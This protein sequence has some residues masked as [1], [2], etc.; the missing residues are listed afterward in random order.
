MAFPAEVRDYIN[1][2]P[3]LYGATK[4]IR[5]DRL[6]Q[7]IFP[8]T[9]DYEPPVGP[10]V[11]QIPQDN[12]TNRQSNRYGNNIP[13][14]L[15]FPIETRLVH[16]KTVRSRYIET[17][18]WEN[19]NDNH[20]WIRSQRYGEPDFVGND[21]NNEFYGQKYYVVTLNTSIYNI[22][23]A[24]NQQEMDAIDFESCTCDDFYYRSG[25]YEGNLDNTYMCKHMRAIEKVFFDDD[26][27]QINDDIAYWFDQ[28]YQDSEEEF[29]EESE[30]EFFDDD[31]F[32]EAPR[33][34]GRITKSTREE[35][36]FDYSGTKMNDKD[37]EEFLVNVFKLLSIKKSKR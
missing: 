27:G 20:V 17:F 11:S 35:D 14:G 10:N 19:R 33:R 29:E 36:I 2:W 9:V 12:P 6:K 5:A 8:D 31:D 7:G 30:E 13:N 3:Q 26:T 1:A 18:M 24:M 28:D 37:S 15:T 21:E 23:G 22:A 4:E 34:S 32:S 25:L 16:H